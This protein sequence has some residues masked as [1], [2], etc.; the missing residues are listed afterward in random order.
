MHLKS[1]IAVWSGVQA[2]ISTPDGRPLARRVW[3]VVRELGLWSA[4]SD[5]GALDGLPV[6]LVQS[7][8]Y[9]HPVIFCMWGG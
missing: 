3:A 5:C 8:E 6:L 2:G 9:I 4:N 1:S 7:V